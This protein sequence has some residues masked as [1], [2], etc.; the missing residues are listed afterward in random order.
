[1][2][3]NFK[4][5]ITRFFKSI[6]KPRVP[7]WLVVCLAIASFTVPYLLTSS[8]SEKVERRISED[9][10]IGATVIHKESCANLITASYEYRLSTE[11]FY[12]GMLEGYAEDVMV[13]LVTSLETKGE[14]FQRAK[15]EW[16]LTKD[17]FFAAAARYES[18]HGLSIPGLKHLVQLPPLTYFGINRAVILIDY[19]TLP[20]LERGEFAQQ[21]YESSQ[22]TIELL[23]QLEEN[24][25]SMREL[26]SGLYADLVMRRLD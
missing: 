8:E 6:S 24:T 18:T 9:E 2:K 21:H 15:Q 11:A 22:V 26:L 17:L 7:L 19:L 14:A 4:F 1:M 13:G 16:E 10:F 23:I 3:L 12:S 20:A 5:T 25:T